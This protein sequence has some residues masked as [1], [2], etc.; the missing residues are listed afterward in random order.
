VYS[1]FGREFDSLADI[2]SF[3][4]APVVLSYTYILK[5][6]NIV[7]LSVLCLYL[8]CGAF[9]LARFNLYSKQITDGFFIGLPITVGGG[10]L[11][12]CALIS[13]EYG[14]I[15]KAHFFLPILVIL[16]YLM[17]SKIKYPN[18]SG[19]KNVN[20]IKFSLFLAIGIYLTIAFPELVIWFA[21]LIYILT[22]HLFIRIYSR[23]NK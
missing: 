2:V 16:S 9:R 3:G 14:I 5:S 22:G 12:S 21:F 10:F 4:L 11:A 19:I 13:L 23:P 17:A 20:W 15:I 8:I 7:G 1:D 6:A 18:F